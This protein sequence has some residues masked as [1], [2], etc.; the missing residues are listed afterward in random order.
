MQIYIQVEL[1]LLALS[2]NIIKLKH[3]K[4]ILR[5]VKFGNNPGC[6]H[7]FSPAMPLIHV[8]K[9]IAIRLSKKSQAGEKNPLIVILF[10]KFIEYDAESTKPERRICFFFYGSLFRYG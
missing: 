9:A 5:D 8:H 1:R 4:D 7:K 3:T 6:W 10:Y 2:L